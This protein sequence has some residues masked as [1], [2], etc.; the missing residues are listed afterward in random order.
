MWTVYRELGQKRENKQ[1]KRK[2]ERKKKISLN[3]RPQLMDK[4]FITIQ[5]GFGRHPQE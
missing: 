2:K 5:R 4:G 1:S 3:I